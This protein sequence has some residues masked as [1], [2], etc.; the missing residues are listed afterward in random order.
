MSSTLEN[1]ARREAKNLGYLL[2][3]NRT[4]D[5]RDYQYGMYVLVDDTAGNRKSGA[6]AAISAFQRGEGYT[7]EDTMAHL[8]FMKLS[9]EAVLQG[10]TLRMRSSGWFTL[11]GRWGVVMEAQKLESISEYLYGD[12]HCVRCLD[13]WA[14]G[15]WLRTTHEHLVCH[16]CLTA[17]ELEVVECF[18]PSTVARRSG[19]QHE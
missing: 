3:R 18:A 14:D 6:Q 1:R 4:R 10:L 2:R 16:D 19:G 13:E 8:V 5:K 11:Q 9:N 17:D 7:L 12:H 15:P